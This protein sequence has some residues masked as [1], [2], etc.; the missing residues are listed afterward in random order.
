MIDGARL[1]ELGLVP[2]AL[3]RFGM[4]RLVRERLREQ[5]TLG[6]D[7]QTAFFDSL[8]SGPIAIA[9]DDANA[10]HYEVP[11]AF[12]ATVLGPYRKYSCGWY[13]AP[14]TTLAQAETAML[15]LT[16]TRAG[17]A[18]GM[19]LL[20]LGCGWG[21]L[22]LWLAGQY[23]NARITAVS[24]STSQRA[25][26]EGEARARGFSN[27]TVIT[28]N[29]VSWDTDARFDRVLSIEMFEHMH[30]YAALLQR[31]TGWLK[32]DGRLFTHVFCCRS[33]GY[34]FAAGDGWMERHFFTGGIMPREDQFEQFPAQVQLLERWWVPGHHYQ[35]TCNDWLTQLDAHHA[36]VRAICAET[37]GAAA[38]AVWVQR[39]RMFFMACAELFGLD[40]GTRFG[41]V[42][43][44]MARS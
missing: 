2:D 30:N 37:Y 29:A 28:A 23:P 14:S 38:A 40:H 13:D 41:V 3:A 26:I 19:D 4:R 35:R 31:V 44:L 42:H 24:N 15:A 27:L 25:F 16:C 17:V 11:S 21:S 8:R 43:S 7:G 22:S 9:T 32:P 18:D 6:D 5:V 39:W 36:A 10:Q 20:D 12:F 34:P 1:C 33:H